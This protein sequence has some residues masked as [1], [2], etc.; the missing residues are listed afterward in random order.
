MVFFGFIFH[1]YFYFGFIICIKIQ[2]NK[3]I[4]TILLYYDFK[5]ISFFIF[6]L[7]AINNYI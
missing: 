6:L 4:L 3:P 7:F 5:I 2:L 1:L